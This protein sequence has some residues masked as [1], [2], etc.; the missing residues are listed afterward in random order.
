MGGMMKHSPTPWRV[1]YNRYDDEWRVYQQDGPP[2]INSLFLGKDGEGDAAYIVKCVNLHEA[3]VRE[4]QGFVDRW[5]K[6]PNPP[7]GR[8]LE[9]YLDCARAVLAKCKEGASSPS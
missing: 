4:L 6:W 7:T 1:D 5:S 2:V 3:L 8:D 9:I